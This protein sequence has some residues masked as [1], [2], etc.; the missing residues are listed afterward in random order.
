M[1]PQSRP[2]DRLRLIQAEPRT[3]GF[4]LVDRLTNN[5]IGAGLLHFA[6]RRSHNI[7]WQ[8]VEVNKRAHAAL[9]GHL[10]CVVWFTGLSGAGKSTIANLVEKKLHALG[11]HTYLPYGDNVRH[12][13]NKDLGLTEALG[14]DS[15]ARS[16]WPKFILYEAAGAAPLEG[17]GTIARAV[18]PDPPH[19]AVC[20]RIYGVLVF[21]MAQ[22]P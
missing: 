9:K 15:G 14:G 10:P 13:L 22:I 1:Q 21:T 16:M 5:T 4:I 18:L 17:T 20:L 7:H 2:G 19:H 6:L 11:R 3:G 8:A 12:A